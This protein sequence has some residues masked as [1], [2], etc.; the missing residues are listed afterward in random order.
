MWLFPHP[1]PNGVRRPTPR[2]SS[3]LLFTLW[4]FTIHA[5]CLYSW[6][7]PPMISRRMTEASTYLFDAVRTYL[8]SGTS[9]PMPRWGLSPHAVLVLATG[10]HPKT[11]G[12]ARSDSCAVLSRESP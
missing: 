4:G 6:I 11:A 7:S 8:G 12:E 10:V 9:S 5:A 3:E 1:D 2:F